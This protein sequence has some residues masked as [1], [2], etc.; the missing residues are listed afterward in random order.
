MI[1]PGEIWRDQ[2]GGPINLRSG[3]VIEHDGTWWWLGVHDGGGAVEHGIRAYSSTDLTGWTDHGIV[4]SAGEIP[5][6]KVGAPK[7]IRCPRTGGLI[8]W[9]HLP[10]VMTVGVAFASSPGEPF[11]FLHALRDHAGIS[12]EMTLFV[13]EDGSIWHVFHRL[14]HEAIFIC[15]LDETGLQHAGEPIRIDNGGF[16]RTPALM[17]WNGYYWLLATDGT[18]TVPG[19]ACLSVAPSLQGP[20]EM[21]GNPCVGNTAQV[22]SCF[23]ARPSWILWVPGLPDR[24]FLVADGAPCD[25]GAARHVWLPFDFRHGVPELRWHGAWN[26]A[27]WGG[28]EEELRDVS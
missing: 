13:D 10:E 7:V 4:L 9:F 26:P 12:P 5:G 1:R 21:T 25:G 8:L 20:W 24:F 6:G 23:N 22:E 15:R 3:S 28:C 19:E 11:S 18:D 16:H 2:E 14:G 17:K 27:Q